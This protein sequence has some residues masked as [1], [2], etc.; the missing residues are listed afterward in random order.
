MTRFNISLNDGVNYVIQCL[1]RMIGGELFVP[2]LYSFKITD[3]A[4][5]ILPNCKMNFI[6]IRPGEKIHEELITSN[7]S[8]TP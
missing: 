6:G 2:K 5:A 7:D 1:N 4:K 3:L 8:K